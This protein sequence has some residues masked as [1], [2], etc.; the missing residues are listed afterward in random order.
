LSKKLTNDE[1]S[2][3]LIMSL[4]YRLGKVTS[5]EYYTYLQSLSSRMEKGIRSQD[6]RILT[7]LVTSKEGKNEYPN[8]NLYIKYNK[9]YDK[10]NQNRLFSEISE[11]EQELKERLCEKE[12]E[13]KL[14]KLS[15]MLDVLKDLVALKISNED[16]AYYYKHRDEIT[17][18]MFSNF[19]TVHKL[20]VDTLA[21][22]GGRP[23][24]DMAQERSSAKAV[25]AGLSLRLATLSK[26]E[27][28]YRIALKRNQALVN[29]TIS[30]MEREAVKVAVL[31]AG[32]FHTPGITELLRDRNISYVVVTP[33]LGE[34][35]SSDLEISPRKKRTDFEKAIAGI[36]GALRA[37]TLLREQSFQTYSVIQLNGRTLIL[38]SQFEP[39]A[40]QDAL[41]QLIENWES[42]LG[43][44]PELREVVEDIDFLPVVLTKGKDAFALGVARG[45]KR[46]LPFVFQY[47][48]I[49]EKFEV[50]Y[51][52]K[53]CKEFIRSGSFDN[54]KEVRQVVYSKLPKLWGFLSDTDRQNIS[55]VFGRVQ[56]EPMASKVGEMDIVRPKIRRAEK[57]SIAA[58]IKPLQ[59][60]FGKFGETLKYKLFVG[61]YLEEV[62]FRVT[63]L[64]VGQSMSS[65]S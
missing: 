23:K 4:D 33:R 12:E 48:A 52:E 30:R 18:G 62:L 55:V 45:R 37:T 6:P 25:V 39:A 56:P 32:G 13:R 8:L 35:Y 43:D 61:P 11:L 57:V 28:F 21:N 50:I 22:Q 60:L 2:D 3:L 42:G 5:A 36:I 31:I 41:E 46:N 16:L 49:Q 44:R 26:F 59:N 1:L 51:G 27:E 19:I 15:R 65:Y 9:L 24:G 58:L 34:N 29:N 17:P 54:A 40:I 10:I 14:V 7:E 38:Y 53:K 63:A 20:G 47:N 64:L